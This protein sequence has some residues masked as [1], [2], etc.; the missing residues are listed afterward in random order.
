MAKL[1]DTATGEDKAY[2]TDQYK[3]EQFAADGGDSSYPEELNTGNIPIDRG[4]VLRPEG[5]SP[6][7]IK[8]QQFAMPTEEGSI[9]DEGF[10]GSSLEELH[11]YRT[12]NQPSYIKA[13]STIGGGIIS[14]VGTFIEDAGYILDYNTYAAM[15]SDVDFSANQ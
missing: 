15:F 8:T 1:R 4:N 7:S 10:S 3:Q 2:L 9:W 12:K 6:I 11:D 5:D 13:L 14:G